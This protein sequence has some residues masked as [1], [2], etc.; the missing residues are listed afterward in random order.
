M[1]VSDNDL[2]KRVD[3]NTYWIVGHSFSSNLTEILSLVGEHLDAVST[4]VRDENLALVV[5]A[6]TVR[7]LEITRARELLKDVSEHVEDDD[8]QYLEER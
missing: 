3:S 7:E 2:S 8:S 1:V 6:D 5:G 4:V